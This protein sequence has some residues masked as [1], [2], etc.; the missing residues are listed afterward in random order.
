MPPQVNG[1]LGDAMP[2]HAP[3][4]SSSSSR[5]SVYQ[6]QVRTTQDPD[7]CGHD[8]DPMEDRCGAAPM[9]NSSNGEDMETELTGHVYS[10]S[11]RVKQ[12]AIEPARLATFSNWP[13]QMKQK[14]EQLSQAGLYYTGKIT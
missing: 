8:I 9:Q 14:P 5:S 6:N 2:Y 13:P 12:M 4:S 1:F 7:E 10:T 3:P 11:P